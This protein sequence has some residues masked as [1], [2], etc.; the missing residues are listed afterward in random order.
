MNKEPNN[1]L[2]TI[3]ILT[4]SGNRYRSFFHLK[5]SLEK[6]TYKNYIHYISNDN[7]DCTFLKNEKHIINVD[8][9]KKKKRNFRH[10]P[11]NI[12]LNELVK[13]VHDGWIIIIDDDAKFIND[14]F[15]LQLARICH[16]QT[17][18][19]IIIF[20]TYLGPSKTEF[21]LSIDLEL[22]KVDMSN[23][24]IHSS[25]LKKFPFDDLCCG[26]YH[27]LRKLKRNNFQFY[28]PKV[29]S[30]GIWANYNGK[31]NGQ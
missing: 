23:I 12:Y 17:K 31:L 13:E 3:H 15:L 1:S 30:K 9:L 2:P 25:V 20:K 26:D 16:Y 24:C 28:F 8:H 5:E 19:K 14:N 11:Y 21:P 29:L 10:C 22:G 4:R 18:E 27:L 7:K 6:Q